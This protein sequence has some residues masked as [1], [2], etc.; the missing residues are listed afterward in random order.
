M[1]ERKCCQWQM[2]IVTILG[3]GQFLG[4]VKIVSECLASLS[5]YHWISMD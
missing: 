4:W 2:Y 3:N 5:G 1:E